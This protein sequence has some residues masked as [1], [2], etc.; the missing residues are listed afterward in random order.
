MLAQ[1]DATKNWGFLTICYSYRNQKETLS[2]GKALFQ[3]DH[4]S[5]DYPLCCF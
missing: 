4:L 2:W 1:M 3:E 5:S